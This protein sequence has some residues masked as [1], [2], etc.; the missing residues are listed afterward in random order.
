MNFLT[1]QMK[2]ELPKSKFEQFRALI[3]ADAEF[4]AANDLIDYSM[5]LGV[6][7]RKHDDPPLPCKLAA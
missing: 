7:K 1:E 5:L 3:R 6:Y 2:V 4:L